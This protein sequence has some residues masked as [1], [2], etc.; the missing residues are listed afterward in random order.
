MGKNPKVNRLNVEKILKDFQKSEES[1][2]HR[3]G[4]F[5]IGK[6]FDE[7]LNTILK[8]RNGNTHSKRRTG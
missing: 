8:A 2:G 1:N 7:A 3:R 5:K 4:T 6:P